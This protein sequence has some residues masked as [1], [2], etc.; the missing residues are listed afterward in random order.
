[1]VEK[2]KPA[3]LSWSSSCADGGVWGCV[4]GSAIP[5][6]FPMPI[7]KRV[8]CVLTALPDTQTQ[9]GTIVPQPPIALS[10]LL[11]PLPCI[12]V[13]PQ[14]DGRRSSGKPANTHQRLGDSRHPHPA[15][16]RRSHWEQPVALALSVPYPGE[17]PVGW[18]SLEA[19]RGRSSEHSKLVAVMKT[20]DLFH[21][22][23]PHYRTFTGPQEPGNPPSVWALRPTRMF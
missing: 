2:N 23:K 7:K 14:L 22:Q 9:Q 16:K 3:T 19:I 13:T 8:R 5:H 1:M 12:H 21:C 6:E 10:A 17:N 11:V 4:T 20:P 18:V 15:T